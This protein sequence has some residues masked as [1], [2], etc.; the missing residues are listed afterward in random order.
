MSELK[1]V[2]CLAKERF[3]A[4]QYSECWAIMKQALQPLLCP[5]TTSGQISHEYNNNTYYSALSFSVHTQVLLNLPVYSAVLFFSFP[6]P[7]F[8]FP[9]GAVCFHVSQSCR[10]PS[11][12]WWLIGESGM[13]RGCQ[14]A[15]PVRR[16]RFYNG[17]MRRSTWLWRQDKQYKRRRWA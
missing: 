4:D 1:I 5:I 9:S 2:K 8:P 12:Q 10:H 15:A 3:T 6:R 11:K 17:L 16:R 13:C 14:W 7:P